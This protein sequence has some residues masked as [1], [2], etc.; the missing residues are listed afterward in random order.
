[1]CA[2]LF[3]KAPTQGE[4]AKC[5]DDAVRYAGAVRTFSARARSVQCSL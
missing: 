4:Q 1:M 5:I 3:G 2:L